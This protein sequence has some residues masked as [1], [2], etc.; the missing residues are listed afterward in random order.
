MAGIGGGQFR[1]ARLITGSVALGLLMIAGRLVVRAPSLPSVAACAKPAANEPQ[2]AAS[3]NLLVPFA[4][5]AITQEAS[6]R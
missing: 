5:S 2:R 3:S 6:A 1:F 4:L